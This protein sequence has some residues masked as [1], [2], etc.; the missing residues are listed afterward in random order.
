MQH[1]QKF[2]QLLKKDDID[3]IIKDWLNFVIFKIEWN[4]S[5]EQNSFETVP[6]FAR[7]SAGHGWVVILTPSE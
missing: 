3:V 1:K 7:I 4:F 5:S 2:V 6:F